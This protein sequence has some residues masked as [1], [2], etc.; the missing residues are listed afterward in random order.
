MLC[1]QWAFLAF[2]SDP[3]HLTG[4]TLSLLPAVSRRTLGENSHF[5]DEE[6]AAQIG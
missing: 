1:V 6:T 5:S 2:F 3:S 4:A